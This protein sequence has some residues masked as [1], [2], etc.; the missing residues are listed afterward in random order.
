MDITLNKS[1]L[2]WCEEKV[3]KILSLNLKSRKQSTRSEREI[4]LEGIRAEVAA[5]KALCRSLKEFN[6]YKDASMNR[7]GSDRGRDVE[8]IFTGL[9]K[10]VEIKYTPV[11]TNKTG[12]LFLR[13]PNRCGLVFDRLKHIDDSY[14]VL[15]HSPREDLISFELLG[16]TDGSNLRK[17]GRYNPVPRK[18]GQYETFGI[19]WSKLFP[20]DKLIV[21]RSGVSMSN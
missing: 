2:K 20:F 9:D 17:K 3:D 18:A 5:A 13:P 11:K 10:P 19:H 21:M 16:W 6:S 1:D 14:F 4:N 15:I 12:F 8:Q 7:Q